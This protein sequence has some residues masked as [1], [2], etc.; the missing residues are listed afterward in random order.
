[1]IRVSTFVELLTAGLT[2]Y[3]AYV[4]R[5]Q[6]PFALYMSVDACHFMCEV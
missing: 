3:Q 5:L 6:G 1:M 4:V 2:K